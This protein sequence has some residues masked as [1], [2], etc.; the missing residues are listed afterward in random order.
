MTEDQQGVRVLL[1]KCFMLALFVIEKNKY[2]I[3]VI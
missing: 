1:T 3:N 2:M